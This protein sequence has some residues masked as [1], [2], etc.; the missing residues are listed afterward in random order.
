MVFFSVLANENWKVAFW[1]CHS[2][3]LPLSGELNTLH[4]IYEQV[5]FIILPVSMT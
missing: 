4:I 2:H 3:W 5:F 1:A